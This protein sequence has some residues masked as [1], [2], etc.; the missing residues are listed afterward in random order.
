MASS[1]SAVDYDPNVL[2]TISVLVILC[3]L[4]WLVYQLTF[5]PLAKFPG[6]KIAAVTRLYE[7]YYDLLKQG[8]YTFKIAEMHEKYGM[9]CK[10]T[11]FNSPLPPSMLGFRATVDSRLVGSY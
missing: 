6:P 1:E 11:P 2:M 4:A 9:S 5:S 8:Q 10:W 7:M 3:Y